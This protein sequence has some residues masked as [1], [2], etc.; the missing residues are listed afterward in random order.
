[1]ET[2]DLGGHPQKAFTDKVKAE[3]EVKQ[4]NDAYVAKK[5]KDL[6]TGC[7]YTREAATLYAE[8]S[9]HHFYLEEVELE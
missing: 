9:R 4:A 2:V 6:M 3:A 8:H 1:M 5:I 7:S